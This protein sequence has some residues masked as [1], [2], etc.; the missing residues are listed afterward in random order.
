LF[1]KNQPKDFTILTLLTMTYTND[2]VAIVTAALDQ[3]PPP[4]SISEEK[5]LQILAAI[6]K[7]RVALEPPLVSVQNL[8]FSVCAS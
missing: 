5:R 8:V 6:D 7:A 3:L 4:E 1:I 2:P